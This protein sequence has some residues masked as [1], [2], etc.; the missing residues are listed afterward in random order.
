MLD[1]ATKT[2]DGLFAER[3]EF[4][5]TTA[6]KWSAALT[7]SA[8][9]DHNNNWCFARIYTI[10]HENNIY[11]VAMD[12]L[13]ILHRC[14]KT[15]EELFAAHPWNAALMHQQQRNCLLRLQFQQPL[16]CKAML[17]NTCLPQ[18]ISS[19]ISAKHVQ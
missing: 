16:I 8:S 19:K 5:I 10:D 18:T 11:I 13:R 6:Q 17:P 14:T 12:R 2:T 4:C 9:S 1:R 7:T 15:T 3:N